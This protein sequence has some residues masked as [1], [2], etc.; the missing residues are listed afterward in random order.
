[1]QILITLRCGL[2]TE[3]G[4]LDADKHSLSGTQSLSG[5]CA[6]YFSTIPHPLK[7]SHRAYFTHLDHLP[8]G[9]HL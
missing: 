1:M 9:D 7:A 4:I 6:L 3:E 8:S 2:A 5:P